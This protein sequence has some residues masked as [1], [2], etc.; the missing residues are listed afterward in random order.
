MHPTTGC[1]EAGQLYKYVFPVLT[2]EIL[3]CRFDYD[4][5]EYVRLCAKHGSCLLLGPQASALGSVLFA[6]ATEVCRPAGSVGTDEW[7]WILCR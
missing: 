4:I 2:R 7:S 3:V 5:V 1:A 6:E